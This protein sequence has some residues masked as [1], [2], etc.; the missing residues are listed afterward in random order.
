MAAHE[1]SGEVDASVL[2]DHVVRRHLVG[3][4]CQDTVIPPAE[5]KPCRE[6]LPLMA[7]NRRARVS[8]S[9]G[10][11]KQPWLEPGGDQLSDAHVEAM[12]R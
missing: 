5:S 1:I 8:G 9:A 3:F 7:S 6:V 2:N 11:G 12:A 4:D 10:P